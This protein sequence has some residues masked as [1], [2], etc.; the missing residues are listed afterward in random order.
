MADIHIRL[1]EE[2]KRSL[3][4]TA[5]HRGETVTDALKRLAWLYVGATDLAILNALEAALDAPEMS[6]GSWP[7]I[8][9]TYKKVK[10]RLAP[11]AAGEEG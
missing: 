7:L 1:S 5:A 6:P 10:A 11:D 8:H 2:L 3:K 4:A 9:D